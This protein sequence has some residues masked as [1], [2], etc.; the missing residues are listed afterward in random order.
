MTV[1]TI[2]RMHILILSI[3]FVGCRDT[4]EGSWEGE[5][6]CH[7]TEY[8]VEAQFT[9]TSRY[10]YTGDMVFSY[11]EDA[12][13]SG[14]AVLFRADLQYDFTTS[15]TKV[16][17]GQDIYLDMVWT[18]LYCE[19]EYPDGEIVEGGCKNVGEIDDSD[20]GE[21]VGMVEM[22]YSGSDR[23]SIDDDNCD[24]TLYLD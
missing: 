15:Q 5:F 16:V 12:T 11:E 18:K 24:G 21:A 20:K 3:F 23:I 7:G 14:E 1:E 10:D 9:E 13:F 22:R 8:E 17:G 4:L 19:I 6:E 2:M